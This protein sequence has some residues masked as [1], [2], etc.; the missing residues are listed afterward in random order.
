VYKR[1]VPEG[2]AQ[3]KLK[4]PHAKGWA[5]AT[6]QSTAN[7]DRGRTVILLTIP[8]SVFA[9]TLTLLPIWHK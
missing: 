6:L 2:L 3:A 1:N 9:F 5:K 4:D 8:K 7:K